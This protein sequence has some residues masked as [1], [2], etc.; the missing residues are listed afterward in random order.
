MSVDTETEEFFDAVESFEFATEEDLK[1][2]TIK[3][4]K[5]IN[6]LESKKDLK[7]R[8]EFIQVLTEIKDEI[9]VKN[10]NVKTTEF[11][12]SKDSEIEISETVIESTNTSVLSII[13]D[14]VQS[15][16]EEKVQIRDKDKTFE[17]F[18]DP[19]MNFKQ[20]VIIKM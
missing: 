9:L 15:V 18:H 4:E 12:N 6:R 16:I 2:I 1:D 17:E 10:C 20:N 5:T 11:D 13:D 14:K 19:Q 3:I 7:L 8:S